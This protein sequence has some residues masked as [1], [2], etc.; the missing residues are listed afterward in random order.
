MEMETSTLGLKTE[1]I[2]QVKMIK[3]FLKSWGKDEKFIPTQYE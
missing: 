2:I 3:L 1:Q